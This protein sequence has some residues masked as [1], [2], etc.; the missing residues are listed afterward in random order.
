MCKT[1]TDPTLVAF[2]SQE[3]LQKGPE[4]AAVSQFIDSI[5]APPAGNGENRWTD[6]KSLRRIIVPR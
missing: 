2:T 3:E 1:V 5:L 6:A 4:T